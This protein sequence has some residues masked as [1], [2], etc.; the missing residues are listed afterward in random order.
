MI[1]TADTPLEMTYD[2]DAP[3]LCVVVDGLWNPHRMADEPGI[4]YRRGS[5]HYDL[6]VMWRANIPARVIA[7]RL[8]S[9]AAGIES[10]DLDAV[11]VGKPVALTKRDVLHVGPPELTMSYH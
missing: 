5:I 1:C 6:G 8:R 2:L 4:V 3:S 11:Q 10:A 9:L 7:H